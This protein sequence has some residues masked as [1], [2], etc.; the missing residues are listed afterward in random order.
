MIA[1]AD[2]ID[3]DAL[4]IRHEFLETPALWLT[5]AQAAR[6]LDVRPDHAA[7]MLEALEEDGFLMRTPGGDYRRAQPL[8]A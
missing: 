7:A 2:A 6:L 8:F 5:V 1:V 4:R 3:A